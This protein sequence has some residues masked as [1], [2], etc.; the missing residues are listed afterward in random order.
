MSWSH[1]CEC[2]QNLNVFSTSELHRGECSIPHTGHL[3]VGKE[4]LI[5]GVKFFE[6][7]KNPLPLLEIEPQ[8]HCCPTCS[9][10]QGLW[11][12]FVGIYPN[13]SWQFKF[14]TNNFL[15]LNR[16]IWQWGTSY[17]MLPTMLQI[18]VDSV[19]FISF[20]FI[21]ILFVSPFLLSICNCSGMCTTVWSTT[22]LSLYWLCNPSS[23]SY[24]F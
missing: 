8:F 12:F 21:S 4:T 18:H 14:M 6:E 3:Y 24:I 10:V 7:E 2:K 17:I 5:A 20:L 22:V 13:K 23:H 9:L 19:L 15:Y 11:N 1:M 16:K